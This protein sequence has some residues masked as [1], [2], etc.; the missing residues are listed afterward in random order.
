MGER[1]TSAANAGDNF[2]TADPFEMRADEWGIQFKRHDPACSGIKKALEISLPSSFIYVFTDARSKDYHLEEQVLNLIQEKQSSVSLPCPCQ[3][4][5]CARLRTC[6][7]F[8]SLALPASVPST[9]SSVFSCV[10]AVSP[11]RRSSCPQ[12]GIMH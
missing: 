3:V 8:V 9:P 6:V 1:A 2:T 11:R 7:F 5:S 10:L 4:R 12:R